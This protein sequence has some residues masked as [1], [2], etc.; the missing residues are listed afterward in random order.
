[1]PRGKINKTTVHECDGHTDG[2]TAI[3]NT[4]RYRFLLMLHSRFLRA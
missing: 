1:M 3:D 2:R 4:L